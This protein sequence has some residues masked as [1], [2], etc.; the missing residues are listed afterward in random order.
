MEPRLVWDV[1]EPG[2]FTPQRAQ[3]TAWLEAR[4]LP[5]DDLYR[6]EF[7]LEDTPVAR[8]YCYHRDD[9]GRKHWG[10]SHVPGDHDHAACDV[11]RM[12]PY[13]VPLR[14]LPDTSLLL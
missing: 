13:D 5:V 14:D 9:L 1:R 3:K 4:G 7:Y 12:D 10:G 8:L 2:W 6:I 11:A